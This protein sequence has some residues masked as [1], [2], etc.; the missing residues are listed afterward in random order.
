[1]W[2]WVAAVGFVFVFVLDGHRR[3][4]DGH[5]SSAVLFE[6]VAPFLGSSTV[7]GDDQ[8]NVIEGIVSA[9]FVVEL[10]DGAT[11]LELGVFGV[12][13]ETSHGESGGAVLAVVGERVAPSDRH[14]VDDPV[15]LVVQ[16]H[17]FLQNHQFSVA[18]RLSTHVR[19][20]AG[21]SARFIFHELDG[22]RT[23]SDAFTKY[24]L[25]QVFHRRI[26][27]IGCEA[28]IKV[29]VLIG[30]DGFFCVQPVDVENYF[31]LCKKRKN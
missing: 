15:V 1:M 23:R 18:V 29:M 19:F 2:L 31:R 25:T 12:A 5:N 3:D 14:V 24:H 8:V 27:F 17:S 20:R 21:N 26:R 11:V 10:V 22:V 16:A 28:E 30:D 6:S 13:H 4:F 9:G 7:V